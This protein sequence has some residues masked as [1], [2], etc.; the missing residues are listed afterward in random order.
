MNLKEEY[1]AFWY[2]HPVAFVGRYAALAM[3]GGLKLLAAYALLSGLIELWIVRMQDIAG[4]AFW[5]GLL[6]GFLGGLPFVVIL[7][8][9]VGAITA[10]VTRPWEDAWLF[11]D[12]VADDNCEGCPEDAT[13]CKNEGAAEDVAE[14]KAE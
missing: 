6:Q 5:Q 4:Y 12:M 13:C 3:A 1:L 14:V 11:E 10:W 7:S 2:T 8:G 9:V